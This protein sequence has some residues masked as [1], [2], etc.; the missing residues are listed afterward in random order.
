M[1][2]ELIEICVWVWS[3]FLNIPKAIHPL[4][5]LVTKAQKHQ[6][7]PDTTENRKV[8]CL[9]W[10]QSH[11]LTKW[12]QPEC[13]AERLGH[14]GWLDFLKKPA[15]ITFG[16]DPQQIHSVSKI[17]SHINYNHCV[18][19]PSVNNIPSILTQWFK[20][21]SNSSELKCVVQ[22]AVYTLRSSP[23]ISGINFQL[24]LQLENRLM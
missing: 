9:L 23:F 20:N 6:I 3:A 14:V 5:Q 7:R 8:E 11:R 17:I 10:L 13:Q 4:S 1:P 12:N 21:T 19:L 24:K 22:M 18:Q 15:N 2:P 16:V